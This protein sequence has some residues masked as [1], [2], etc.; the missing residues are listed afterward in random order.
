MIEYTDDLQSWTPLLTKVVGIVDLTQL[1]PQSL[2]PSD[3]TLNYTPH[4][5]YSS[6]YSYYSHPQC[7]PAPSQESPL[8]E[9]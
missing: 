6:H 9:R 1:D 4:Y 5:C 2:L 3:Q 7:P 8:N